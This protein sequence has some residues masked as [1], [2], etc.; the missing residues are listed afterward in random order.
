LALVAPN[1]LAQDDKESGEAAEGADTA[2]G[3]G[4][5][6]AAKADADKGDGEKADDKKADAAKS[7]EEVPV[8]DDSPVEVPGQTYRFVGLRYRGVIIPKFMM[9]LFGE[10]G[11]TVYVHGIGPEFAI[12]KDAFEYVFSLWYAGYKMD[13][14]PFKSSSDPATGWEVVRADLSVVYLTADFLWSQEMSP[15]FAI[16]YGMGA[17]F[18]FVF[19]D[20]FRTQAYPPSG[21]A[22]QDPYEW[23][24]CARQNDPRG[25]AFCGTDN[26]HY[27]GY[28]EPSWA[29][30]GSKPIIFPWLA[31]QTGVRYK[32]TKKFVGRLD[33][34]FGTSGFFIGLGADYGL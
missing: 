5:D 7:D 4:G 2:E 33:L 34:G 20:L 21:S 11:K 22:N 17:G 30:G 27:N 3:G 9:N 29:N 10:G 25:G 16:N 19:G 18:G 13:E 32:P 12:R 8:G 23:Q 15:E 28:K 6:E 1:A 26:D 24:K 14:T 31:M